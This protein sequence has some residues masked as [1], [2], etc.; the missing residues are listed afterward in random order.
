MVRGWSAKVNG[1]EFHKYKFW[2][3]TQ[4]VKLKIDWA[5]C[6]MDTLWKL[7]DLDP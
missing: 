3:G 4:R 6:K 2:L 1:H 5:D 7:T